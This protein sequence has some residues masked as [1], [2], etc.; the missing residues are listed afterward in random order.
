LEAN[1]ELKSW[2]DEKYEFTGNRDDILQIKDIY[3][4]F[5][6]GDTW[7]NMSKRERREMNKKG[8]T[9]KITGNIHFRKYYKEVEKSKIVQEKYG[10]TKMRNV[11]VGF[12]RIVKGDCVLDTEDGD[13]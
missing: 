6:E 9:E 5:K 4:D 8:F 10:V 12:V 11:F 3:E 13:C 7:V 1:D 2:F